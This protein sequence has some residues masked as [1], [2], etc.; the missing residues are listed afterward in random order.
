MVRPRYGLYKKVWRSYPDLQLAQLYQFVGWSGS[1]PSEVL[2]LLWVDVD[3]THRFYVKRDTKSGKSL[4]IVCS[5]NFMT[6]ETWQ[7]KPAKFL[8][9]LFKWGVW[10]NVA[11]NSNSF[12]K[13]LSVGRSADTKMVLILSNKRVCPE[14]LWQNFIGKANSTEK[15][16][17]VTIGCMYQASTMKRI[18]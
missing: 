3:L 7:H 18:L 15:K 1:R 2:K 8:L 4:L 10:K 5:S 12:E 17:F 6:Q 11:N 14:C 16:Q 13:Y 9:T